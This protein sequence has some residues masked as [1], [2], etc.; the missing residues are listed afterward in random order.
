[1]DRDVNTTMPSSELA[2]MSPSV[3]V[4]AGAASAALDAGCD[5][6]ARL[7]STRCNVSARRLVDP[8]PTRREVRQILGMA[9][10]APDHGLLRPWRFIEVPMH[11]RSEL[12]E[13]FAQTLVERD[14]SATLE[15]ID[16]ARE[17]AHRAPFLMLAVARLDRAEPS[18]IPEI[19]KMVS[20]GAA[21]Q[22]IL[23]MAHAM[24]YGAG[25]TSGQSIRTRRMAEFF[26]LH[27]GEQAVCFINIGTVSKH[28][29]VRDRPEVT[30][31]FS[32][33]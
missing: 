17:K 11:R 14:C 5:V 21:I 16:A 10:T 8:G 3:Q 31:F 24:G 4:L 20:V 1:M 22:N 28:K 6:L 25:L 12:G 18:G 19:E 2:A 13:V 30:S 33:L 15:Q 9:A 26:G 7:M 23:L 32:M 27:S 29:P